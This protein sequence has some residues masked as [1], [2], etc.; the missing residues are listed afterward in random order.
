[1]PGGDRTGPFGLGP[2]RG[3]GMGYCAGFP[4]PG[5]MNPYFKGKFFGRGMGRGHRHWYYATG[6]PFWAR[7]K[8]MLNMPYLRGFTA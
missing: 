8:Y 3:R 7:T 6:L 2:M 4:Q 5:Y 1:M